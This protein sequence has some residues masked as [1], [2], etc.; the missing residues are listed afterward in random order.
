MF[1]SLASDMK[2]IYK[3]GDMNKC[4]EAMKSQQNRD[5]YCGANFPDDYVK[6]NSCKTEDEEFCYLCCETE[7]GDMHMDKRQ[8]CYDTICTVKTET[9]DGRWVWVGGELNT[10][11]NPVVPEFMKTPGN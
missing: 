1:N 10:S 7:F 6:F 2:N 11:I 8:T 5:A 3:D 9:A 4:K